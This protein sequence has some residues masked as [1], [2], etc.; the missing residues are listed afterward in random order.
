MLKTMDN[1][2]NNIRDIINNV[3]PYLTATQ[4]IKLWSLSKDNTDDSKR[5][6]GLSGI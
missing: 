4:W 5:A 6:G 3:W 2:Q 1:I